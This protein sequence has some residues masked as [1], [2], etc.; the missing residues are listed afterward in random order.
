MVPRS[1]PIIAW[2]T[3]FN[4][5]NSLGKDGIKV[6]QVVAILLGR[7]PT[8]PPQNVWASQPSHEVHCGQNT[9]FISIVFK[10][11]FLCVAL[12]VLELPL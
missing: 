3:N 4:K 8:P 12:A 5:T 9:A 11:G 7:G 10:T 6:A 1:E 2:F